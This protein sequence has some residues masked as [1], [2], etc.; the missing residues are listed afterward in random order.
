MSP[1][2]SIVCLSCGSHDAL[3][4][5]VHGGSGA[6]RVGCVCPNRAAFAFAYGKAPGAQAAE[7]KGFFGL[8]GSKA[9]RDVQFLQDDLKA[10]Q[11]LAGALKS[12]GVV[13]DTDR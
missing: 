9:P 3:E 10:L 11:A 5:L 4:T 6:E 8:F 2:R 1:V 12:A 7:A 13:N